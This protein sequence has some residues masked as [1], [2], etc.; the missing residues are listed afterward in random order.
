MD[1]SKSS[2]LSLPAAAVV[3]FFVDKY[4]ILWRLDSTKRPT[5]DLILGHFIR[6][7]FVLLEEN[8]K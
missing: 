5:T 1:I 8:S 7:F 6:F 4:Y 2:F 3:V